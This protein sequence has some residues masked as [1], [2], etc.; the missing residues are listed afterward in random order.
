MTESNRLMATCLRQSQLLWLAAFLRQVSRF[1]HFCQGK[2]AKGLK[3][4][5]RSIA[6]TSRK[7][8]GNHPPENS[9]RILFCSS[10]AAPIP[11][12]FCV[13]RLF[14][15]C[16]YRSNPVAGKGIQA[17]KSAALYLPPGPI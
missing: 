17:A 11:V 3:G 13:Q 7:T 10:I 4:L 9:E 16:G 15:V 8:A 2:K 14:A 5:A 1:S 12:S 6:P